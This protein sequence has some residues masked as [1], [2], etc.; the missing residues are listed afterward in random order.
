MLHLLISAEHKKMDAH[1]CA[2][3]LIL[4]R[5]FIALY[6]QGVHQYNA[7]SFEVRGV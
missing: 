3:S 7:R 4:S 1:L 6:K 2:F 5:Q